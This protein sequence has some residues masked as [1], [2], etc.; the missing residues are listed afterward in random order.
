MLTYL[1]DGVLIH[2]H[3]TSSL[4]CQALT[5]STS[6]MTVLQY[7]LICHFSYLHPMPDCYSVFIFT[8]LPPP[9]TWIHALQHVTKQLQ[10]NAYAPGSLQNLHS[11]VRSYHIFC[12][13]TACHYLPVSI[14]HIC[15]YLVFLSRTVS[16][17]TI[18]NHLSSLHLFYQLHNI[19]TDFPKDFWISLTLRGIK[20]IIGNTQSSKLPIT[21]SIL[22]R[23]YTTVDLSSSLDGAFWTACLLAFFT[24]FRKSNLF[25]SSAT[26]F[27]PQ[28]NLTRCDI[29][30]F[31]SFRLV[32]ITWTKTLQYKEH[33]LS[34]PIARIPH[35]LLCPVSALEHYFNTIPMLNSQL[36]SL[37]MFKN[38]STLHT[39]TYHHFVNILWHKLSSLG[40]NPH[41]YLGHS[42]RRGGAS[43]AFSLHLPA[44]L[45][46]QQCDW[47]SDA[48]LRYLDK[49]LSQHLK[50][51]FAY[52]RAL[53]PQSGYPLVTP[54]SSQH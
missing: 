28:R 25:P 47:H 42:F 20:P 30:L 2:L 7:C 41:L 18:K 15:N 27:D 19:P 5:N 3:K 39:F 26:H 13:A 21:P 43:F 8:D 14:S 33:I 48:Y 17:A 54:P 50:V 35:S 37:F 53:Q 23:I 16:F 6:F 40:F 36:H 44:E 29:Q 22:N 10:A 9:P 4:L 12:A 1:A 52:R 11:H 49:P 24:F 38:G 31:P 34:I 51:A 45:I 46:Q 32:S